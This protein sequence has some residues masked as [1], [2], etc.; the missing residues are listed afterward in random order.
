M[1]FANV[2]M[3]NAILPAYGEDSEK[4]NE[5]EVSFEDLAKEL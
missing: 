4:E 3:Y 1:S 2:G 5:K